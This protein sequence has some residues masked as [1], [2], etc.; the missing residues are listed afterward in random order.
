MCVQVGGWRVSRN[1]RTCVGCVGKLKRTRRQEGRGPTCPRP[2]VGV[3]ELTHH[4]D[5]VVV[6][7]S[8]VIDLHSRKTSEKQSNGGRSRTTATHSGGLAS[9]HAIKTL[10]WQPLSRAATPVR[11]GGT[12]NQLSTGTDTAPTSP[13]IYAVAACALQ[14]AALGCKGRSQSCDC[15]LICTDMIYVYGV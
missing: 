9:P 7:P 13:S 6:Q 8:G 11:T 5:I 12:P 14:R 15:V 3:L 10:P 1:P 2:F 4:H